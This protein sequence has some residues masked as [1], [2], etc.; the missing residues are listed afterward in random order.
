MAEILLRLR[1]DPETGRKTVLVDY[2]SDADALP[3]EHEEAHRAIVDKLIAAGALTEEE[4]DSIV[5][6]RETAPG[7]K[8]E[9][10]EAEPQRG[11]V[12]EGE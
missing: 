2:A 5:I 3:M 7:A 8:V 11:T 10:Q 6:E 12:A 1:V 4:R 9:E